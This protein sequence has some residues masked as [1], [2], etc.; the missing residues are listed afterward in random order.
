MV[1]NNSLAEIENMEKAAAPSRP[2]GRNILVPRSESAEVG[3][4]KVS[5]LLAGGASLHAVPLVPRAAAEG[6]TNS[7]RC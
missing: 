2:A 7:R 5:P 4:A 3:D 6:V 1:L